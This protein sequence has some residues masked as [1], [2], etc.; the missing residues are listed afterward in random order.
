MCD[1]QSSSIGTSL[2][3]NVRTPLDVLESAVAAGI[4][5]TV[6]ACWSNFAFWEVARNFADDPSHP[7]K[8][9][10]HWI[11]AMEDLR[12]AL[13]E[14]SGKAKRECLAALDAAY[15]AFAQLEHSRELVEAMDK[16]IEHRLG[17]REQPYL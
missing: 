13:E 17:E 15:I 8:A 12:V 9:A 16:W 11:Y 6:Q 3:S 14:F 2:P 7:A 4:A 5:P 10:I 1:N